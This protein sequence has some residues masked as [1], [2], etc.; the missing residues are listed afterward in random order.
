MTEIKPKRKVK[1]VTYEDVNPYQPR[2]YY[3]TIPIG[4]NLR[5][6]KKS[7]K[8]CKPLFRV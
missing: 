7:Y 2:K 3:N 5:R 4:R 8:N 1:P 6:T